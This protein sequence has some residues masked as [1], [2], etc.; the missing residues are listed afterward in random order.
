M[1]NAG[2]T[3]R[4]ALA[5]PLCEP[6]PEP[7]RLMKIAILC[8]V[9]HHDHSAGCRLQNSTS[10]D[11]DACNC[12]LRQLC[13]RVCQRSSC[14]SVCTVTAQPEMS[15]DG[16][17]QAYEHEGHGDA[18]TYPESFH[19]GI[20]ASGRTIEVNTAHAHPGGPNEKRRYVKSV[21]AEELNVHPSNIRLKHGTR[22]LPRTHCLEGVGPDDLT[23]VVSGC[24]HCGKTSG[25][26]AG[27]VELQWCTK[28]NL[29]S[30]CSTECQRADWPLHKKTCL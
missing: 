18:V 19:V 13:V 11:R 20:A 5:R 15:R 8:G 3:G 6:E 26:F 16:S 2:R 14:A 29:A 1:Q 10:C 28:C 27:T 7:A 24:N 23:A 21:L 4:A 25:T 30:Y 9:C 12:R 22:M 17:M